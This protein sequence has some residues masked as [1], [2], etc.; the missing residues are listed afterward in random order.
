MTWL[1]QHRFVVML[2]ALLLLLIGFPV[3][4]DFVAGKL[5]YNGLFALILVSAMFAVLRKRPLH[6]LAA[7]MGVPTMVFGLISMTV[8]DSKAIAMTI[9][10]HLFAIVFLALV[11]V[12]ILQTI[13][14]ESTISTDSVCGA[15]CGYLAVAIIFGHTYSLV[16]IA[17]PGSFRGPPE[18]MAKID[19]SEDRYFLLLYLSLVTLTTVGYG[20]IT[21]ATELT[22]SLAAVEAIIGQFYIAVLIADLIGKRLSQAMT[23]PH[24][25]LG[26]PP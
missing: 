23:Q 26:K 24:S 22:R 20:D 2:V 11:V 25:G 4:R 21:P 10:F 18:A 5:I 17:H 8:P 6:R 1:L 9:V 16:E 14:N 3:S 13:Y 7:I 19:V 12:T 15:F